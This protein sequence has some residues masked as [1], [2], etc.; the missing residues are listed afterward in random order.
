MKDT[1]LEWK[2][3][4]A[5]NPEARQNT[6]LLIEQF[7]RYHPDAVM[8]HDPEWLYAKCGKDKSVKIFVCFDSD[9]ALIGYA[10]FFVHPSALSFELFGLSLCDYRIRRYCITAYPLLAVNC[11]EPHVR[12][13]DLFVMISR[14]LGKRDVVFGLGVQL[15]S[16]F[17]QLLGN[18]AELRK[19]YQILPYGSSYQ[20]RLILLPADFETYLKS[21]G[22]ST[23]YEMR[24]AQRLLEKN[25][26]A[27]VS[28]R[29]FSRSDEVSELLSLLEQ[30][31][32]KTYQHNL[33]NL[34]I[35]DNEDTRYI[36]EF[37]ARKGWLKSLILF[38][39]GSPVAFQHGFLYNDSFY[40][41]HMGYDPAW[42]KWS[43]GTVAHA[44]FI[45]D[46]IES[47]VK[48]FDFLYGDSGS[49]ARLSNLSREEQNFYLVPRTFPLSAVASSLRSFNSIVDSIGEFIEKYGIKTRIRKFL[50]RHATTQK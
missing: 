35:N 18:N 48:T 6:L 49:K 22:Y 43:V 45:R 9:G 12:L 21:L 24:R 34:G 25:T 14:S 33:L 46:L 10:P 41:T 29:I 27:A 47:G 1:D 3:L 13:E 50:R 20:R 36:L 42:A 38:C 4:D 11:L 28:F 26:D 44:Y 17:G 5:L 39:Q 37:A 23:R 32:V 8:D 40:L 30:V 15:A 7:I 16:S 19:K 31:S 2:E